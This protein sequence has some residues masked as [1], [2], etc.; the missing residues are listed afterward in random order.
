[1]AKAALYLWCLGLGLVTFDLALAFEWSGFTIKGYYFVFLLSALLS[2]PREI[3]ENG[4]WNSAKRV[5]SPP[6]VFV[7]ALFLYELA[8]APFS[9]MPVKSYAYSVW[10]LFDLTVVGISGSLALTAVPREMALTALRRTLI[11]AGLLLSFVVI[12]DYVA[13]FYGHTEGWIGFNQDRDL[14]WG[15]SRPHAFAYEPSY[16]A[17]YFSVVLPLLLSQLF[18]GLRA[19]WERAAV[20]LASISVILALFILSSRTGWVA[21]GLG[22]A[23]VLFFTKAKRGPV[24]AALGLGA[25][26]ILGAWAFSPERQKSLVADNLVTSVIKGQD[27]SGNSRVRAM[28]DAVR[29]GT[30]T[31]FLGTGVGASYAYVMK[32]RGQEGPYETGA[33]YIMSIWGQL[34]AESGLVG[35]ACFLLLGLALWT[36]LRRSDLSAPLRT[37]L[38]VTL[39]VF[40]VFS[41]HWVGNVA[42]TDI[43]VWMAIWHAFGNQPAR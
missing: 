37:S 26:V 22:V 5:L 7:F 9:L 21:A 1:M 11:A 23:A 42:R 20:A 35:V 19:R 27:G 34:I 6:W 41:S 17:L 10:L 2:A 3:S 13:Y 32:S 15:I 43:W 39:A 31:K 36:G 18:A 4:F 29:I 40:F 25:V 30:E 8:L 28:I 12:A 38:L 33:E 14:K 24:L 16:L